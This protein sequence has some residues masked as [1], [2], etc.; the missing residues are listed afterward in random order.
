MPRIVVPAFHPAAADIHRH[1]ADAVSD[2]GVRRRRRGDVPGATAGG[3][4]WAAPRLDYAGA[5]LG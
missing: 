5:R 4:H 3:Q 1:D 2:A